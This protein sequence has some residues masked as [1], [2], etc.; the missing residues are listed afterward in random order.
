VAGFVREDFCA[1]CAPK[2]EKQFREF[3]AYLGCGLRDPARSFDKLR[4]E[5]LDELVEV[6]VERG[7]HVAGLLAGAEV[8]H[9]LVGLQDIAADLAAQADLAL[10]AVMLLHLGA[11]VV[12]L[13]FVKA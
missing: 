2:T 11:L 9:H 13:Q 1:R 8:L 6:A 10:L 7:L 3:N 4:M 12:Q 5:R